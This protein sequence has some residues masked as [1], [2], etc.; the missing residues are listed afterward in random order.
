MSDMLK[1]LR[2]TLIIGFIFYLIFLFAKFLL[3]PFFIFIVIMKLLGGLGGIKFNYN[4][5]NAKKKQ[6][7]KDVIDGEFEEVD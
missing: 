4:V 5:N 1:F 6:S 3:I 7:K 2:S